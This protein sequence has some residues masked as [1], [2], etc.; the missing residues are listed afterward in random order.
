MKLLR[1][2]DTVEVTGSRVTIG[3]SQVV[4]AREMR[5]GDDTWTIRDAAGQPLW[6]AGPTEARGF[7][8]TKKVLLVVVVTKV[9][10]L[11]TV[12]RH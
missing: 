5:K 2:G 1:N 12:L 10:L 6:N 3:N 11:A 8:T 4:L 7:W 9:A